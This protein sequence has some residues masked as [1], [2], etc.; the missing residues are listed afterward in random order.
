MTLWQK[1]EKVLNEKLFHRPL[2]LALQYSINMQ[3]REVSDANLPG[4]VLEKVL[5]PDG[6]E[7][8]PYHVRHL[9]DYILY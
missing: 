4:C 9:R 6:T 1:L 5:P 3:F 8:S 2:N 7:R